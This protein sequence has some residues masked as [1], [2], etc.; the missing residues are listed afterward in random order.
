MQ[1]YTQGTPP[2]DQAV[3]ETPVIP[4]NISALQK[5][6]IAYTS[7]D[8]TT[9]QMGGADNRKT[10][11]ANEGRNILMKS[12]GADMIVVKMQIV[13][14]PQ[15]IKQDDVFYNQDSATST[16]QFTPNQSLVMD[17]GQLYVFVNFLTPMDYS[18]YD[19]LMDAGGPYS[20]SSF[21][22]VYGINTIDNVFRAGKFEQTLEMYRLEYNKGDIIP[23]SGL[24]NRVDSIIKSA[25][26]GGPL[27]KNLN[28]LIG[29][30]LSTGSIVAAGNGLLNNLL[31]QAMNK[32][33]SYVLTKGK[34]LAKETWDNVS[35][36]INEKLG[37]WEL[38]SL[39]PELT[40][41][42]WDAMAEANQ[43]AIDALTDV[44]SD[45]LGVA[46]DAIDI[47]D[48]GDFSDLADFFG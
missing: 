41:E 7:Y 22:G 39:R 37:E 2:P 28:G 18:E 10:V 15:F 4:T 46:A 20:Y 35:S 12:A 9:Q 44:G 11:I 29:A 26:T 21:S 43:E 31:S 40:D 16:Y 3:N 47:P 23:A 38:D 1:K 8:V 25:I 5:T 24:I 14:D 48:A 45:G 13:G 33:T 32:A 36:A 34:E 42:M 17:S 6:R 19:G 30:G 27:N